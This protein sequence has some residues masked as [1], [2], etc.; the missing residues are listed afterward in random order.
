[1]GIEYLKP[2]I[3]IYVMKLMRNNKLNEEVTDNGAKW[4]YYRK[5]NGAGEDVDKHSW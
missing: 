5:C 1:L 4:K 2:V 3:A